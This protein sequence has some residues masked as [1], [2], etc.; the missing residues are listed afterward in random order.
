MKKYEGYSLVEII[1]T[2]GI[3]IVISGL[4][5][6]LTFTQLNTHT[7]RDYI[8]ALYTYVNLAQSNAYTSNGD[9]EYGVYITSD[10]FIYYEGEDK[11]HNTYTREYLSPASSLVSVD[12]SNDIHFEMKTLKPVNTSKVTISEGTMAYY[13]YINSEGMV[14]ILR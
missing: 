13:V 1:V 2:I 7:S 12:G 9:Q 4:V 8:Y 3:L 11:D 6:S 10:R 14:D 5:Y